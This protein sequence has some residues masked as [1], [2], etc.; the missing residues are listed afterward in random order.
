MAKRL[1]WDE[2]K[3]LYNE[4]WVELT[5]YDWPE[6]TPWPKAGI[7][8]VH[9][10]NRKEFWRLANAAQPSVTDSA[11]VFVGPPDP[12]DAHVRNNLMSIMVCEQ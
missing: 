5:D 2:I 4:E 1:I 3:T 10:P 11:I 6:G 7:V 8:R 12:T 9:S